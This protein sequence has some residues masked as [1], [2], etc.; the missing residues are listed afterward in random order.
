MTKKIFGLY[1]KDVA[2]PYRDKVWTD[3]ARKLPEDKQEI[4][5]RFNDNVMA[6]RW[7]NDG[8]DFGDP[9]WLTAEFIADHKHF[10][11]KRPTTAQQKLWMR[12]A[13]ATKRDVYAMRDAGV[14]FLPYGT[15]AQARKRSSKLEDEGDRYGF[16]GEPYVG[17]VGVNSVE[18]AMLDRLDMLKVLE[19][20]MPEG[21]VNAKDEYVAIRAIRKSRRIV[22][23]RNAR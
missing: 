16:S 9:E 22:K 11:G 8:K 15:V 18:D 19:S 10:H 3:Y 12:E 14:P 4:L 6:S 2:L 23:A 20:K 1:P 21:V 7:R 5:G 17:T 13:N